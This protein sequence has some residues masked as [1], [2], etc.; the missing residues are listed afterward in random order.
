MIFSAGVNPFVSE[1]GQV[2]PVVMGKG[3]ALAGEVLRKKLL[4]G[5]KPGPDGGP[6]AD[7]AWRLAFARAARDMMKVPVDFTALSVARM[8]LTEILELPPERAL[9]LM[10]EGPEE[11]LGLLVLSAAVY[12]A[13]IEVLTMGRCSAQAHDPRKPTRTDAA[14]LSPLVD[15][16]MSNLEAALAE[17]ADLSWTSDFRYASFIEEARP[18]G[19]ML[20]EMPYRVLKAELSLVQG[21]RAGEM[22]LVLPA[23]GRGRKPRPKPN[24]VP[25]SVARPAFA[26]ALSARVEQADCTLTAVVARL[27]MPLAAT[28]HLAVDMVL[29]LPSAALDQISF[30]GLDGRCVA[31]GKL[32]QNRGMRAVRLTS[33]FAADAMPAT[34]MAVTATAAG[35]VSGAQAAWTASAAPDVGYTQPEFTPDPFDLAA[36]PAT[37]TD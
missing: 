24:S 16:A 13:L 12:G 37:G 9:I 27:S 30:D 10:L 3:R 19:L 6:G 28:M 21:Q 20:E 26:A 34:R 29:P 36:F 18:L 14:M 33:G 25:D 7:R 15:L 8:S 32:G 11:G 1:L 23:E 17:D 5:Q 35:A 31:V 4:A 2:G 22:L